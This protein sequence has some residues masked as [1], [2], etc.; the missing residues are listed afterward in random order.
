MGTSNRTQ[1]LTSDR[2]KWDKVFGALVKLLK[3]QQEQLET[4]LKERKILEGRIKTQHESWVSDTRLYEDYILQ[5]KRGLVE[6]DM[7][8]LLE[9]AKGDLMLGLKQ[10]EVSLHKLKLDYVAGTALVHEGLCNGLSTCFKYAFFLMEFVIAEQTEDELADFRAMFS[11]LSQSIK[12][13]SEETAIGKDPRHS[14]LKSGKAKKLEA[15]VEKLKLENEKL[16]FEK[17][18]ELS[19]SQKRKTFVWNQYDILE[20]NLTIKLRIKEAEVEKANEKIAEVLAISES[21]QSS[22]DEKDEIIQRMNNKVAK[23]E[24]DKKKWKEDTSKLSRELELLRKSR[25]AQ[26]TPVMK[27]CSAPLGTFTLGVKSCGKDYNLVRRKVLQS[28]VPSKDAEKVSRSLKKKRMDVIVFEAP[29]LF[30]SSFKVPKV[31][32]TSTPV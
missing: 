30:S 5:I 18:S 26:I 29:R 9:A 12:A 1:A 16:V 4:L 22:N 11:C 23:M 27:P 31:K 24:A 21:L 32:V 10:G 2:E 13:N 15:E 8:C 20:S 25:S 3:N 28:A 14:D 19:A 17:N 7:A 6:K